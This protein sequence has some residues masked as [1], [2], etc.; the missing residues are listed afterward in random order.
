MENVEDFSWN[1]LR[2]FS[3]EIEGRKSAKNFAKI[4]GKSKWGLSNGGL[5]PLSA[6]CAQS[7]TIVHF[8]GLL[9]PFLRGELSSQNDDNCRQ[10][11]TIVD[12]YLKPPFAKPPFR[13]SEQNFAAFFADLFEKFRK[14]FALG[15]CGHNKAHL[16]ALD[17]LLIRSR[18]G[19][20]NQKKVQFMNFSQG[21][22]RTKV[23]CESCLFSRGKTP[24]FTKMG[25]IHELFVLVLSLVWFAGATPELSAGFSAQVLG[26]NF[27]LFLSVLNS[28]KTPT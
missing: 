6:I 3:L 17:A 14:N 25:E 11:W 5:R 2:P 7:S 13:L 24:E 27:L 23:Q 9:G 26:F 20:P 4:S 10:S 8:C 19:K 18:P 21:C 28:L 16:R 1:F 22:S 12:K 15:G